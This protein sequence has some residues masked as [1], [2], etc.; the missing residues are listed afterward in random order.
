MRLRKWLDSFSYV[1]FDV[2]ARISPFFVLP[3]LAHSLG[4]YNFGKYSLYLTIISTVSIFFGA[5]T[6]TAFSVCFHRYPKRW[7][8]LAQNLVWSWIYIGVLVTVLSSFVFYFYIGFLYISV[9]LIIL[10]NWPFQI[11]LIVAINTKSR[12]LYAMLQVAKAIAIPSAQVFGVLYVSDDVSAMIF[13]QAIATLAVCIVAVVS[14]NLKGVGVGFNSFGRKLSKWAMIFSI[15][16]LSNSI[17][18]WVRIYFDRYVLF[19]IYGASV[20]GVYSLGFQYASVVSV[21]GLS[22]GQVLGAECLRIVS[23]TSVERPMRYFKLRRLIFISIFINLVI[24][25]LFSLLLRVFKDFLFS[26]NF[27]DSF[28][29]ANILAIGFAFQGLSATVS[30]LIMYLG[31]GRSVFKLTVALTIVSLP[32]VYFSVFCY[33]AL[34]SACSFLFIWTLHTVFNYRMIFVLLKRWVAGVGNVNMVVRG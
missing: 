8:L 27:I 4:V 7:K 3:Y 6:Q 18:G 5:Q 11:A 15:P 28:L 14:L 26:G 22:I 13:V 32:L 9:A 16:R 20:L 1:F 29:V 25:V 33:G 2:F 10:A 23:L 30:S 31:G 19:S 12:N 24:I 17:S 21:I 34:G